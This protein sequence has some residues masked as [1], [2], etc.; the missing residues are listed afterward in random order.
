MSVSHDRTKK[1]GR[2]SSRL[3]ALTT[4]AVV[5]AVVFVAPAPG[6]D[7]RSAIA[8][9]DFGHVLAFGL[10]TVL[11]W[12]GVPF[13]GRRM[14]RVAAAVLAAIAL[15][16]LVEILQWVTGGNGDVDDV[17]R[18]AAGTLAAALLILSI[19]TTR[20]GPSRVLLL[21]A[22]AMVVLTAAYPALSAFSDESVARAQFP[23]LARFERQIELSRFDLGRVEHVELSS[24]QDDRGMT[25]PAMRVDLPVGR[26]PGFALRHFPRD[27]RGYTA[28]SLLIVNRA[29]T[30]LTVGIRI[31]DARHN[32]ERTDRYDGSFTL[33]PGPNRIE[34][35]LS[36]VVSAPRGRLLDI[37][38]VGTVRIFAGSLTE[39]R[40]LLI[41]P[42][43]LLPGG[44]PL[45]E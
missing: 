42:I 27:W 39:P 29:A 10:V 34:I 12:Y 35:P 45:P 40:Q 30:P 9:H 6:A 41:G 4:T 32:N 36:A 15:G 5:T 28:L 22:S 25:V 21:I 18:D 8:F 31:D 19:T 37:A 7:L 14:G 38:Q 26:Y 44:K 24:T 23:V 11:L 33:V 13:R 43:A 3:I 17:I 1:A 16:V 2:L 20:W